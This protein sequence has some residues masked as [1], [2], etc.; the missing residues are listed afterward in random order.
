MQDKNHNPETE[1]TEN[2][3]SIAV[4]NFVSHGIQV[5]QTRVLTETA[6]K[7]L[8]RDCGLYTTI[9]TGP[10]D[11]LVDGEPVCACLSEQLNLYLSS[12]PGKRLC[13]CGIGNRDLTS[14]SLGPKAT[15]LIS[16]QL[17]EALPLRCNFEKIAV[18]C[19][20]VSG[21]TNLDTETT[22]AAIVSAMEADCVLTIDACA[23]SDIEDL[24]S[25]IQLADTGMRSFQRAS[26][27][28][29]TTVGVP[30]ISIGVPTA[31]QASRLPADNHAVP[32]RLVLT[33]THVEEAIKVGAFIITCAILQAAY[34]ELDYE[35]CKNYIGMSIY[36]VI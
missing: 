26:S 14:D 35:T 1:T 25:N 29:E 6:S 24:C 15:Q 12:F 18:V 8:N 11:Q 17:Y 30:V 10:L 13:I 4:Q 33:P 3:A 22:I 34:P 32:T 2:T 5:R 16:P 27:L 21:I 19:P 7:A 28:Q 31:I 9:Q 23:C 20:S 36:G